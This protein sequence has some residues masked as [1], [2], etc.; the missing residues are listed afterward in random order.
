MKLSV[1]VPVYNCEKYIGECLDS[2]CNQ[3]FK[4]MEI[5]V[6]NDASTDKT[7]DIINDYKNRYSQIKLV[8]TGSD[9]NLGVSVARNTGLKYATGEYIGFVDADDYVMMDMYEKL[10]KTAL[11]N[12]ADIVSCNY[13][14]IYKEK[15]IPVLNSY[16]SQ[17]NNI[18]SLEKNGELLID[19]GC[20]WIRIYKRDLIEKFNIIFPIEVYYAEDVCFDKRMLTIAKRIVY[21]PDALY[22]YRQHSNSV[23]STCFDEKNL[24]IL[25]SLV[26]V[27]EFL[28]QHINMEK[29]QPWYNHFFL[30]L[31]SFGYGRCNEKVKDLYFKKFCDYFNKHIN[32]RIAYPNICRKNLPFSF[33]LRYLL[34]MILHPV[35]YFSLKYKIRFLLDLT[36]Q[37]RKLALK[38]VDFLYVNF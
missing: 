37:I 11:N 36:I 3:T 10:V 20:I 28:E 7:L 21:I 27:K 16:Y 35:A 4:D 5:I 23:T 9:T 24:T 8:E 1:I 33:R 2:L 34:L 29:L 17:N 15:C 12:D 32:G 30:S 31:A 6:V 19:D 18:M 13:N 26:I 38:S 14:K 25:K 22:F